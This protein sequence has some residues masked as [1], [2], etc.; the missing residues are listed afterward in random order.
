MPRRARVLS[1]FVA[2][3]LLAAL[4]VGAA[5]ADNGGG[6]DELSPKDDNG[7]A[8]RN[9]YGSATHVEPAKACSEQLHDTD[10][11]LILRVLPKGPL[12]PDGKTLA[13]T[14]GVC[15]YLPPNYGHSHLR[16]PVLYLLHGGGGDAGDWTAQGHI[17]SIMDAKYQADPSQAAIVVMPD[18]T[19]AQWYDAIDGTIQNEKYMFDYLIPY[20]DRH[21]RTIAERD[22][23]VIDGLSNGGYGA[24]EMAAKRPDLFVAAGGMSSNIA[25]R[26]FSGLGD[27]I[28]SPAYVHG[29]TP[30]DLIENLD[31]VDLTLDIGASCRKDVNRDACGTFAFE[32]LFLLD[33]RYFRDALAAERGASDGAWQYRETEGGHNWGW[34]T[35]WLDHRHLPFLYARLAKPRP[36]TA[37]PTPPQPRP[38]FRYRSIAPSFSAWGYDVTVKRDVREFLDL[39]N[40]S[41]TSMVV[42]GS[43]TATIHT[44]PLYRAGKNYVVT[45]AAAKPQLVPADKDGRL[46]FTVD[47]GPSHTQEEYSPAVQLQEMGGNYFTVRDVSIASA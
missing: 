22:G 36:E 42:Q 38:G 18:G 37:K 7:A 43:G 21:F 4:A 10:A 8:G 41:A 30:V 19:D 29:Y 33:N 47:L 32:Q 5:R 13:F 9:P 11:S 27:P 23:R 35:T 25:G 17:R 46:L 44:A 2:S 24:M 39:H 26:S 14:S 1:V 31:G 45:G 40:V 16:Y 28:Q 15:I 3:V 20:V 34:W 6:G 12:Q